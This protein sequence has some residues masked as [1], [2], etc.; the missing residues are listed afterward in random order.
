VVF[1]SMGV[2]GVAAD[3]EGHWG[4]VLGGWVGLLVLECAAADSGEGRRG[5][6]RMG[7]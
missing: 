4:S 3:G 5:Q 2:G 6:W 1:M 7:G